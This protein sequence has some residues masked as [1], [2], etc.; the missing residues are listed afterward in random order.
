MK[1]LGILK[2]FS[3]ISFAAAGVFGIASVK[4][5]KKAENVD[6]LSTGETIYFT[7]PTQSADKTPNAFYWSS[8]TGDQYKAMT[9]AYTNNM[10]QAVYKYTFPSGVDGFKFQYFR[11][12]DSNWGV[13]SEWRSDWPGSTARGFYNTKND[14]TNDYP[15]GYWDLTFFTVAFNKNGGTGTMANKTCYCDASAGNELTANSFTRSGYIFVGWNTK[16]DGSGDSYSDQQHISNSTSG[17]TVTLYAQWRKSY[18]SGRYVVDSDLNMDNAT[19]MT[20]T[21]NEYVATV[22][23]SYKQAFKSAWY[24]NDNGVLDNWFGYSRL[25]SGCGAYHYFSV[26]SSDNI[27]CYARGIYIVYVNNDNISI[28]LQNANVLTSEHLAAQLMSFGESPS[29]GHC[30]D[31]DRFPAMK[32]IYLNK[33]NATEKSTFQDYINSSEAQFKNAYDRY[34]AWA[35]AL[36]ENP[37]AEGKANGAVTMLGLNPQ[38]TNNIAIIVIIS[39]VSVGAIGGYFFIRKRKENI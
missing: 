38:T 17:A 23:L 37:W 34:I 25:Y 32:S 10:G 26:D 18:T 7:R 13:I 4:E 36:G 30:G 28:E 9:Y 31:A 3:I 20:Y 22:T 33:L 14:F 24:N 21:N 12:T 35:R 19:L 11:N 15:M 27:V 29:T 8:A 2:L 16:T 1:K 5:G 6:A 39:V